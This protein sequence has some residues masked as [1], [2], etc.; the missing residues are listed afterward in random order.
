M[1]IAGI[2][3]LL[4]QIG[5]VV[6]A[7]RRG[8][9][10]LWVFLIIF[11][12]LL[13]C[14][15][16]SVMVLLS[17]VIQSR[18]ARQGSKAMLR[19]LDPQKEL[20]KRLEALEIS[21]TIE[22]RSALAEE[23]LK[24]G[25]LDEAITLY[26]SS[27]TGMYRTDPSLRL[28]LAKA[29]V[30]SGDFGRAREKLETLFRTNPGFESQDAHLLYARSL[31]ALGELDQTLDEYRALAWYSAGAEAK[32]RHALLLKRMGKTA[33]ARALFEDILKDAKLAT[34]HSRRLNKEWVDIA[35]RELS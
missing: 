18:T 12:P 1:E 15:L 9:S 11:L 6:H 3:I 25:M 34:R 23:Y 2:F 29:L 19:M 16:Y 26:E 27:L 7:I 22:N 24:H 17:E 10:L 28:G 33:E 14:I 5:F 20:R 21:D 30:E 8:H 32:C 35:R 31:E 13:G 4:I